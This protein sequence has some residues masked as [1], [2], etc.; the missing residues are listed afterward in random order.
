MLNVAASETVMSLFYR[1][2]VFEAVYI[3]ISS[4]KLY[5]MTRWLFPTQL[6]NI[7]ICEQNIKFPVCV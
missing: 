2:G 7:R 5:M 1:R 4:K 3:K 6:Q